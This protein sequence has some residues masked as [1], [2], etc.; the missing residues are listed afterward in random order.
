MEI[1]GAVVS[2]MQCFCGETCSHQSISKTCAYLRKPHAL[3][4]RLDEKMELLKA[5]EEDIKRKL[6][7]ENLW[8][9]MEPKAEV[10]MWLTNVE[11]IRSGIAS[12]QDKI[13][14]DEGC[15]N[16]CLPNYVSR[17]KQGKCIN[18][19]IKEVDRLLGQSIFPDASLVDMMP[20]RGKILPTTS[21]V[22]KTAQRSL[23]VVWKYLNDGHTG[24]IGIY[25]MGGVGK[26]SILLAIN[27]QL[28]RES[29]VFDNVIWVTA[30]NDSNVQKLQKD[31]ARAVGLSFDNEDD[32]MTRAA[33]LHE[34]LLRR[35]RFLLIID[36]LWEAFPLEVIGIPSPGYGHECKLIITT[37]SMMVCRGMETT[38]EVEVSVLSEEEAWDLFKQKV[39]DEVLASPRLKVVAKDVSK[40]CG[41]L[42]LA[43]VTVGR[44]L[45]R[46]N[47]LR[48][49]I[50]ALSQLKSATG[51]IEG[52]ENRVFARLRFSYERLKDNVTKSCFLYCALY[53]EDHHI[54]TE[55]LIKYWIWEGLLDYLGYG[56]S[57]MLQ[58]KMIL[59][60]LK[61]A[62]LLEIGCQE[63]SLNEYV[64]MHDLIRD[65]AIAVT[66]VSPLFMIRAGH[67]IRVPPVESEWLEGLE[68]ISLMRNDLCSLN[69][70]PRCP[71]LTTLLLQYN[72]LSKGILPSFFNH[73]QNLKVLDLSYTG[74]DLLPDSLSNLEN[75]RALLLR[76]CWNLREVPTMERL[77]ELRFLDLSSTSI[78]C[79]Q[80]MEMLLNL[81]H[82][83]LS[84]AK[85]YGFD[86][87]ILGTYRFLENLLMLGLDFVD[88]VEHCTNLTNLEANFSNLQDFNYYV[89]SGHWKTLE[90]FKFCIGYPQSSKLPG[91]NSV[92]FFGIHIVERE[93]P[94]WLPG[95][96]ELDIHECSGITQL[97][98]FIMNASS[99]LKRCKIKYCDEMEWIITP[100]WVAFP[101]LELL[102]IEGLSGLQ[103]MCKGIPPAGTLTN[104]K[105]LNVIACNSLMTLLPLELVQQ[106]K[107]LEELELESCSMLEE[108]VTEAE[109]EEVIQ[110]NNGELVLPCLRKLRLVSIPRL[111]S[112]CRGPMVCDSLMTIEVIDCPLLGRLPFFL[113]I[114]QQLVD[115]LKQIKGS[116]R[117]WWTLERNHPTATSLLAPLVRPE[118][119]QH[120]SASNE[121][122]I[123]EINNICSSG[124]SSGN[125]SFGPR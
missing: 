105:V 123:V 107:N 64:K 2:M 12:I 99:N 46:E 50:I 47:D 55:E 32:E 122:I 31:I 106:L 49:W 121:D 98:M 1:V 91:K 101:N 73:L 10:H 15:L 30:S 113:E 112:I 58:G 37:R 57:K 115:S 72:S 35:S 56:E 13:T 103:N 87:Q 16:G 83:D 81:K 95:I 102:E 70:E 17:F 52:M 60:E 69:F 77:K 29:T 42:P 62:C 93:S 92:G 45:R 86:S 24:I 90:S 8:R 67:E 34:A 27:N 28:L 7:V 75:L 25:G 44:A 9:G 61:N 40:E 63:G 89:L 33:Q 65:M 116:R 59:D 54:E 74:I 20:Q 68:R 4:N 22:G 100:E 117:W 76:S 94:S 21:L 19:K 104:L 38:R 118:R 43:I 66:R 11:K 51:R 41:G 26:T 5:R 111:R 114:R 79:P 80:G 3:A 36:D 39:G 85:V 82:L 53:P 14:K 124:G 125:S 18:K 108:I 78:V 6:H 120:C 97:P 88:V 84:N 96:L 71:Q 110:E 109:N 23:E 48:Q 119:E